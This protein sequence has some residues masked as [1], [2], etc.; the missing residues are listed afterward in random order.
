MKGLSAGILLPLLL[1]TGTC[2]EDAV[3]DD[4][5]EAED[6]W[7]AAG[8]QDYDLLQSQ[9]CE[10]YTDPYVIHVRGGEIFSVTLV[11]TTR[12]GGG[13]D[14]VAFVRDQVA[15]TVPDL[16][17]RYATF[18][19]QDY[20]EYSA[21]WDEELGYPLVMWSDFSDSPD[22]ADDYALVRSEVIL[23]AP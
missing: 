15:L 13:P 14:V 2:G 12:F 17:A 7:E 3:I 6:R 9:D 10:C 4:F 1:M 21:T 5:R 20:H 11:D 23:P 19:D 8:I 18:I 22:L 16:F